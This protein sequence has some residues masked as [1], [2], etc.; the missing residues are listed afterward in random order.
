M[1]NKT[2]QTD[3]QAIGFMMWAL[4]WPSAVVSCLTIIGLVWGIPLIICLNKFQK[5]GYSDRRYA[6]WITI[7]SLFTILVFCFWSFFVIVLSIKSNGYFSRIT[8]D[9]EGN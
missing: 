1:E 8:V 2:I 5:S 9:K 7:L 3:K 6:A 4:S